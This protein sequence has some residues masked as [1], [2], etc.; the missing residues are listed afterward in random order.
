ME[1]SSR[2]L[3]I[4][5]AR[6]TERFLSVHKEETIGNV[7]K[8][9]V[10]RSKEFETLDY[11]YVVDTNNVLQGV[12][13]LK[14]VL[15]ASDETKI[16]SIMKKDVVSVEP[17]IDQ[18]RIIYIVLEK[19]LKAVPVVDKENHLLG[20]VPYNAIIDIFHQEFR[21]DILKSAGIHHKIEEIEELT[22]PAS[23]LVRARLPSLIIGLA[24][25][26]IAAYIVNGYEQ[27]LSSYLILAAFIPVIIYLSDAVGTQSQTL[28]VRMIAINPKFSSRNYLAR[29]IKIGATL[30]AIFAI[31]LFITASVGWGPLYFGLVIGTSIFFS[32]LFQTFV[33]TYLSILL[34][35]FRVD[36][37]VTSGPITTIISDITTLV[38]YFSIASA[39]LKFG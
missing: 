24:G 31:L 37:A 35:K 20:V 15:Q 18:E 8:I 30:G 7:K 25:G 27:V 36:P 39:L 1:I 29:E 2:P 12:A 32:M 19:G 16:Q 6:I 38:M 14:E 28:I 22:T 10:T 34:S 9:L 23:R 33:A 26:L 4:I 21:E 5:S 13:S 3:D 17:H 11:I